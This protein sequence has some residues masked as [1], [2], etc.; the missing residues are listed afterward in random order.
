[1]LA[2]RRSSQCGLIFFAD[3]LV[4]SLADA[5]D[6]VSGWVVGVDSVVD[7]ER[8]G[9]VYDLFGDDGAEGGLAVV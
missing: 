6:L 3:E 4:V 2:K 1:M 9:V 7:V 8:I 5:V